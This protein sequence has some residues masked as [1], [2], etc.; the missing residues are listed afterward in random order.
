MSTQL[1]LPRAAFI[2]GLLT[3]AAALPAVADTNIVTSIKPLELLV[4]AVATDD[5][6]VTSLV[7]PGGSPHN[8]TLRPS[9]RR[10]LE[11]A[12][13][14]F[15]VGP[16]MESFLIGL[17]ANNEFSGRTH[18][19]SG[20]TDNHNEEAPHAD[21]NQSREHTDHHEHQADEEKHNGHSD[22]DEHDNHSD[23]ED[24]SEHSEHS[25]HSDD[26]AQ[27][28]DE[29]N[30]DHG[31]GDDPHTWVDPQLALEMARAIAQTLSNLDSTNAQAIQQN[32]Q[33]FEQRVNAREASIR[34]QL[35]PL[36]DRKLF[37][38]HSAFTRFAEHYGLQLQG[39]L[40]LNPAFS[41]G[42]KHIAEVQNQLKQAGSACLLTEPQFNTQWWKGITEGLDITFSTWDPL[43][44]DIPA[45]SEGYEQ[46]QQSI[47]DAVL[48]CR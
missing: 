5:V 33:A 37:S 44:T 48:N 11:Q 4:R 26:Y 12:D 32:L 3:L 13:A 29:R 10:A 23:K 17:L 28:D 24:H 39:V 2:T 36:Q 15:W 8:Y 30:H 22:E 14:I 31:T 19:L 43:A 6:T 16:D 46:F 1:R 25:E 42:A 38:Y 41:P 40:T 7:A 18:Q 35:E 9:Q 34:E 45:T 47:A 27:T 21:D 20:Q